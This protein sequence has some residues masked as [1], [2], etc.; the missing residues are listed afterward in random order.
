MNRSTPLQFTK[1]TLVLLCLCLLAEFGM[2]KPLAASP[3]VT[4]SVHVSSSAAAKF[5]RCDFKGALEQCNQQLTAQR[6]AELLYLRGQTCLALDR[7]SEA[8]RDFQECLKVK[9]DFVDALTKRANLHWSRGE[10]IRAMQVLAAGLNAAPDSLPV[11]K[12]ICEWLRQN[13][14]WE[15]LN[16]QSL[17]A[18]K[19]FP[20]V[21]E[22][23]SC[24]AFAIEGLGRGWDVVNT[25]AMKAISLAPSCGQLYA[26][27]AL[28]LAHQG[29]VSQAK[30]MLATCDLKSPDAIVSHCTKLQLFGVWGESA[31]ADSERTLISRLVPRTAA[32]VLCLRR[33]IFENGMHGRFSDVIRNLQVCKVVLSESSGEIDE[34]LLLAE[35]FQAE[36]HKKR[37]DAIKYSTRLMNEYPSARNLLIAGRI[38]GAFQNDEREFNL[39]DQACRLDPFDSECLL[40]RARMLLRRR[41]P[42]KAHDLLDRAV[43]FAPRNCFARLDRAQASSILGRTKD[44]DEDV[45]ELRR[46]GWKYTRTDIEHRAAQFSGDVTAMLSSLGIIAGAEMEKEIKQ[47]EETRKSKRLSPD[48]SLR[49]AGLFALNKQYKPALQLYDEAITHS[50]ADYKLFSKRGAVFHAMGD[51]KSARKDREE[52]RRLYRQQNFPVAGTAHF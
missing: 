45:A 33:Q 21:P 1:T 34:T 36:E 2:A 43:R 48:D 41:E 49:L 37:E 46:Q 17:S 6:S 52:A 31:A 19:K 10:D 16:K 50:P 40:A 22:F 15:E 7:W 26:D 24:R 20:D 23:H 8:D 38:N 27:E 39:Y 25:E 9:P 4:S 51:K 11:R 5:L 47:L 3:T 42:A 32:D 35:V 18:L 14:C 28:F 44:V 29:G 30:N 12:S 13:R